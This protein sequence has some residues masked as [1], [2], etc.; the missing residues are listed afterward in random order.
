MTDATAALSKKRVLDLSVDVAVRLVVIGVLMVWCFQIF[1]PFILP[2]IWGVIIAVAL[3]PIFSKLTALLG[4]R[5]GITAALFTLAAIVLIIVPT[6]QIADSVVRSSI[7]L[8]DRAEQGTLSIPAPKESVRD[9][10][11][12]GD[13]VHAGRSL[14]RVGHRSRNRQPS[15]RVRFSDRR[16]L[17]RRLVR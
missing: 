11:V 2:M 13:R 5:R 9:W 17:N 16:S 3:A 8:A 12:V 15:L 1:Q 7:D 14:R 4:G 10:P 6:F